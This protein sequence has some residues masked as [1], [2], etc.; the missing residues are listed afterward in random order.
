MRGLG[1]VPRVGARFCPTLVKKRQTT[2][3]LSAPLRG[4]QRKSMDFRGSCGFA[5]RVGSV[6]SVGV[7]GD[8]IVL[9]KTL[10]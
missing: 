2:P 4:V 5:F 9:S 8:W 6:T 3:N 1:H 7:F 10:H